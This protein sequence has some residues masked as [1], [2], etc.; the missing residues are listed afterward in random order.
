MR[1]APV[2]SG[3]AVAVALL[4]ASMT[5]L[6]GSTARAATASGHCGRACLDGMVDDYIA[7]LVAHDPSR[8]PIAP[9]ARFV[10][11]TVPMKPGEGL[12]KTASAGPTSFKIYV[13]DPVAQQVG[14][15]GVM[16]EDGK[17]IELALRLKIRHGKIVEMEHLIARN[18][19]PA[20][21]KNLETPRPAFLQT[22]PRAERSSRAKMLMIGASYYQALVTGNGRAAPFAADCVR[23]ENGMQTTSNTRPAETPIGNTGGSSA[24]AKLGSLGCEAQIDTHT[25]DYI[26]RIEPRRVWIADPVTGLVF[27]LSQFRQPMRQKFVKIVGVPG[28]DRIPMN[29]KPFDLPAAHIFKVSDGKIHQIEAMGFVMPYDSKTGWERPAHAAA[30]PHS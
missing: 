12:W 19:R 10:Q 20:S 29:F 28:V 7:A 15:L 2:R 11:N 1:R 16:Q 22:V 24:M 25:F 13:P 5:A 23:H 8:V 27:G 30:V 21:L 6:A 18:L 26:T 17:P 9:D 4:L 14:F 3:S